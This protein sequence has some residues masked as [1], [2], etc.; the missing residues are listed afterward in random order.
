MDSSKG[1]RFAK[2]GIDDDPE[3]I[4]QAAALAHREGRYVEAESGYRRV[5]SQ[6]PDSGPT[7]NALGTVLLDQ[8]RPD[9]ARDVFEKAAHLDPPYGPAC[10]NLGMLHQQENDHGG[11]IEIYRSLLNRRPDFGQAWNNLG[12]AYRETGEPEAALSCFRKAV[13][14]APHMAEAWNNLGVAQDES[15][16]VENASASYRK[17]IEIQPGYASAHFNLGV[18][19]Q[20]LGRFNEAEVQYRQVLEVRPE[21]EA[22]KFMLQSLDGSTAPDAA[23]SDHVR[24]IFDRCAGT[25][26]KTLVQELAYK[27]PERLFDLLRPHLREGMHIL[28]LGCGTGLGADRYRPF[29]KGLWGVDLSAK[30]LEKAAEKD[31]YDRLDVFDI[32]QPWRFSRTFDLIYS[33]D[34]FVYFGSLDRVIGAAVS[35]LADD[36]IIGFSVEKLDD[37]S[38]GYRLFPSGRYAH[39]ANYVRDCLNRH[40]L[41]LTAEA[42]AHIRMQSGKPVKGLLVVAK[43]SIRGDP[44]E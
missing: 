24:R 42:E 14:F 4:L 41:R 32:L 18:S 15:N 26:E 6:K 21:D 31:I 5:L 38:V 30:M 44:D 35:Y 20:K 10:Y 25:F 7:L 43:K 8:A 12:V 23:P 3:K 39:T 34:V 27:T 19:L 40:G 17:A 22:A 33:A 13:A 29:A 37:E 28:D 9:E 1:N 2:K 11:A 36:G 16:H